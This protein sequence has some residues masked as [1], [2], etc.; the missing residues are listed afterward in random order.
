MLRA[1]VVYRISLDARGPDGGA[2]NFIQ[3]DIGG[4][5]PGGGWLA[6]A[7]RGLV[8]EAEQIGT[9][10]RHFE[11]TFQAEGDLSGQLA[12]RVLTMSEREIE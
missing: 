3:A 11:W 9:D 6:P 10:W 8:A 4:K 2:A 5:G 1:G 12:F 7:G